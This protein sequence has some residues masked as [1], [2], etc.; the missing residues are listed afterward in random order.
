MADLR[1]E[2]Y[3]D[4]E[5]AGKRSEPAYQEL[6][7]LCFQVSKRIVSENYHPAV[8]YN[9]MLLM[10]DLNVEEERDGETGSPP[11]PLPQALDEMLKELGNEAQ[12][13]A[14]RVAALIGI[15]RHIRTLQVSDDQERIEEKRA[16]ITSAM[17]NLLATL[18]SRPNVVEGDPGLAWMKRQAIHILGYLGQVGENG[19]VYA[20]VMATLSDQKE[21]LFLRCAAAQALSQLQYPAAF[22]LAADEIYRQL[23]ILAYDCCDQELNRVQAWQLENM[24]PEEDDDRRRRGTAG[25]ARGRGAS[26]DPE[27][28]Y[29]AGAL[30]QALAMRSIL[31]EQLG[32]VDR[33][34]QN[35]ESLASGSDERDLV[36]DVREAVTEALDALN[37]RE[38]DR[39]YL[40]D[41]ISGVEGPTEDLADLV[42]VEPVEEEPVVE[43]TDDDILDA[44]DDV[45]PPFEPADDA[46]EAGG[47]T[48]ATETDATEADAPEE[49][50]PP[51]A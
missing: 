34:L 17:L 20:E 23:G 44:G 41:F 51:G 43:P 7:S 37:Q 45:I 48:D 42:L 4:L 31:K 33:A 27:D 47:D 46:A 49:F 9:F 26:V 38:D 32:Y 50:I 35:T 30:R 11:L 15:D 39:F 21:P 3:S 36:T 13:D 24:P 28:I 8:R 16:A 29:Q 2:L 6:V 14:V 18:D 25:S 5:R 12:V 40:E 22:D 1:R 10:G 19:E